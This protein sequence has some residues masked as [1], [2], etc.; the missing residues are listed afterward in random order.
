[1]N[2]AIPVGRTIGINDPDPRLVSYGE[3]PCICGRWV[4]FVFRILPLRVPHHRQFPHNFQRAVRVDANGH[5]VAE[6]GTVGVYY[7][8]VKDRRDGQ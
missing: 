6:D 1:M 5:F 7:G 3:W 2:A 4:D 8:D